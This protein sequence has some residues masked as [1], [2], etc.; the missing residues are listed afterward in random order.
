MVTE[1]G[2]YLVGASPSSISPLMNV[3]MFWVAALM[4][5]WAF[6]IHNF[7]ISSSRT[8]WLFLFSLVD[9]LAVEADASVI[10]GML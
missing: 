5:S 2:T 9:M 4:S 3:A 8:F 6:E 10:A 1:P 7:A